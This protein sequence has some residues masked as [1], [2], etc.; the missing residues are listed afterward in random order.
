MTFASPT[1]MESDVASGAPEQGVAAFVRLVER[2]LAR[3][4][5]RLPFWPL[6]ITFTSLL[7]VGCEG[8]SSA[9]K[10]PEN[11]DFDIEKI[12]ERSR[13]GFTQG[14]AFHGA[15]LFEST[16]AFEGSTELNEIA[17]DDRARRAEVSTL[18]SHGQA[19]FGEGR[20]ADAG[21]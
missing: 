17:L 13:P 2:A 12:F 6:R 20:P 7:L 3:I 11:I 19:V 21:R 8:A 15:R 14:L 10:S 1:R 16:G 18:V 4:G 5:R 9:C